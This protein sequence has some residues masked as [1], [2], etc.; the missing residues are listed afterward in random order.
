M[1]MRPVTWL[2]T[3]LVIGVLL[4][5]PLPYAGRELNS[6]GDLAHAPAFGLLSLAVFYGIK[7]LLPPYPFVTV[8]VTWAIVVFLGGAAE[9]V[10]SLTNRSP[11]WH[12]ALANALGSAAFLIWISTP[13][14]APS[15]VRCFLITSGALL[16]IVPS[17]WPLLVLS[18]SVIQVWNKPVLAS[19]E[20]NLE[21][22]RWEF[23]R[24]SAIRSV[25][26]STDGNWS[27][28]LVLDQDQ[29]KY[30]GVTYAWPVHDWSAYSDFEFDAYLEPGPRLELVVKIEDQKHNG[31]YEDRFHRIE[32]LEPGPH[33]VRIPLSEVKRAPKGRE[34]DLKRIRRLEFFTESQ[35]RPF[36]LFLDNFQLR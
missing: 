23:G 17:V 32:R 24:C 28:R 15:H 33:H 19:F 13:S 4:V 27:L 16:L 31:R 30:A 3:S 1:N 34:L 9:S 29:G 35:P 11:S 10:Q 18:D 6:L 21:L 7:K 36:I 8:L 5:I 12:D 26:H 25:E 22:S 14:A 2:I 20:N